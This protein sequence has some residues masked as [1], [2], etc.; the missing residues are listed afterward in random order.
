MAMRTANAE[1]ATRA[2]LMI[3]P[4]GLMT[5]YQAPGLGGGRRSGRLLAGLGGRRKGGR[6][7]AGLG[8]GRGDGHLLVRLAG[9]LGGRLVPLRPRWVR[10]GAARG[11][12]CRG[13]P[14]I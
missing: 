3:E 12:S 5:A 14:A 1:N 10:G 11:L 2:W 13:L 9:A 6:L 4:P 7:L 8:G